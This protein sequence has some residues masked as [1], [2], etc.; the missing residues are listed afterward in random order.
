MTALRVQGQLVSSGRGTVVHLPGQRPSQRTE[1]AVLVLDGARPA[2]SEHEVV[3]MPTNVSPEFKAADARYRAAKTDE[4]RLEALEEMASTLNKHKGTEKLYADIKHRIKTLR[5][6]RDKQSA[7]RGFAVKVDREG[8]AQIVLVGEPNVGKSSVLAA[9]TRA[10]PE[11]ADYPFTTRM[12]V[13]GMMHHE[14][15]G[16][17]LVD[18]PPISQGC[19]ESWV[20][21]VIRAAD[22]VVLVFDLDSDDPA[23]SIE[24]VR[25]ELLEHA[26][27]PLLGRNDSVPNDSR[28]APHP[29]V[30]LG[31]HL[32]APDAA[33]MRKLVQETYPRF[34][35]L[36]LSQRLEAL[37]AQADRASTSG[38]MVSAQEDD[39]KDD[40]GVLPKMVFD[41]LDLLRV[42]AKTPG[43][44]A[45]KQK[46]FVF[47][48][49]ATLIEF[50][51]RVHKDLAEK[52]SYARVWGTG[53]FDGQRVPRE[54]VLTEGD[55][56]ELHL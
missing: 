26:K 2:V 5:E 12:P 51:G 7:K 21:N 28:F 50:A 37:A 52:L 55:V 17:Q 32:D 29:A 6:A 16:L 34:D 56:I 49:G 46:P 11:I 47:K 44:E 19:T 45:D 20:Y 8:A 13:L 30:L 42:Y 23:A 25:A 18:L 4:E 3:A 27:V 35:V 36:G 9:V 54:Y 31:T 24:R 1:V 14:N 22:A 41:R 53:K 33:E 43:K 15:V 40:R 48:R 38:P 10:T 39:R